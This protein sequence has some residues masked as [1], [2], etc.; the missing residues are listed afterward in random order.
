MNVEPHVPGAAT[1][2]WVAC[3]TKKTKVWRN[4]FGFI[5]S[6][7]LFVSTTPWQS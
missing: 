3:R 1:N 4:A 5:A 7:A 2:R 6:G